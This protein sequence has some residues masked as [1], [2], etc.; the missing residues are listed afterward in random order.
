MVLYI[1]ACVRK[2]SRTRRLADCLLNTLNA[3]YT[4][5]RLAEC[6][7]PTVDEAFLE[8]RDRLLREGDFDN[9]VFAYARQFAQ[10]D[11]IIIAAPFWDLSFPAVLKSYLEQI[12]VVGITFRYTPEGIPEGL[13]RAE[14]LYYVTTAGGD[15]FPE[16]YG[17]GY[18]Q[19]LAQNFYHIKDVKL[20]K[21]TGCRI[22][23]KRL[24]GDSCF[25][26]SSKTGFTR[27]KN[28]TI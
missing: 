18:I 12:N 10:A 14:R 21:A 17:F 11:E 3:P 8:K 7:F 22:V 23:R 4:R 24:E 16:Q 1:D 15:F 27:S 2:N 28:E 25:L 5:L 26:F 19:A 13:C 9:P 20:I 6:V